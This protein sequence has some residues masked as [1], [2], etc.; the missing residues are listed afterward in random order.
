MRDSE[1]IKVIE[2]I[3]LRQTDYLSGCQF[4]VT[5]KDPERETFLVTFEKMTNRQLQILRSKL[6]EYSL[7]H[8]EVA[9]KHLIEEKD[10]IKEPLKKRKRFRKYRG[11]HNHPH[12]PRKE[13]S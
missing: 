9:C 11:F 6:T 4:R 7:D 10:P 12:N 5:V 2:A 8:V 13:G 3:L 1:R